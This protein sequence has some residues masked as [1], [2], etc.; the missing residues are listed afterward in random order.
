MVTSSK[1]VFAIHDFH[2]SL[3]YVTIGGDT[4]P[5]TLVWRAPARPT[6]DTSR[7]PMIRGL[8]FDSMERISRLTYFDLLEHEE[9][10]RQMD[11]AAAIGL[12]LSE[13][14]R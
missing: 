9:V 1:V 13:V 3:A 14:P 8:I 7:G 5:Q 4:H 6:R 2:P 12:C 11:E 10:L